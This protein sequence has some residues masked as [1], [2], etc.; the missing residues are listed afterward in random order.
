L[1]GNHGKITKF[2]DHG[3]ES[4]FGGDLVRNKSVSEAE[5]ILRFT[6][7]KASLPMLKLLRSAMATVKN[8][9]KADPVDYY[10]A[11]LLV[12]D[13]PMSERVFPRSRGR[14][15]KI[16]KRTSHITL[17]L[18]TKAAGKIKEEIPAKKTAVKTVAPAV[19][20]KAK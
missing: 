8:T 9:Y 7:K 20:K 4:S 14:A 13:G 2:E 18:E 16:A 19:A 12:N 5:A 11:K 6:P 10:V 3:P 17:V 1:Y 15:D